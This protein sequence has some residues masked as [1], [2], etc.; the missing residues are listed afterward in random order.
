[1]TLFAVIIDS[2]IYNLNFQAGRSFEMGK[3]NRR[4]K[5][6]T[7]RN[8]LT[9]WPVLII[10]ISAIV[11]GII[12]L[13]T[14]GTTSKTTVVASP[15]YSADISPILRSKCVNCHNPS[16]MKADSPL[17]S[18]QGVTKYITPG[19]PTTSILVQK[20]DGGSMARF[21]SS[22]DIELIKKWIEQ[23]ARENK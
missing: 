3:N 9:G 12:Y 23:G 13:V 2:A 5:S 1:M 11:G 15:T 22:E 14:A 8:P 21:T 17:D 7:S 20:I 4:K 10:V 19:Q 18:Y 6:K 16:G